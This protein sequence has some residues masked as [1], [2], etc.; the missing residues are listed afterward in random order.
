MVLNTN[1]KNIKIIFFDE[2][3]EKSFQKLKEGTSEE[4]VLFKL[5]NETIIQL[6]K[7]PFDSIIVKKAQIPKIY[8]QKYN[9]DCLRMIK[10]NQKWRLFYTIHSEKIEI[11]GIIIE[12][13]EHKSY[14]K[15]F[16]YKVKENLNR[17]KRIAK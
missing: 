10:L 6:K 3:I 17:Y 5:I 12:W 16:N 11:M 2:F 14:E 4:K 15:K 9:I 1:P 13:L 7:D 8:V